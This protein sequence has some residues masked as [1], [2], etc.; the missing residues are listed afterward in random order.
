MEALQD[1]PVIEALHRGSRSFVYRSED[2]VGGGVVIKALLPHADYARTAA[3]LRHAYEV[4]RPFVGRA[5]QFAAFI[6][7]EGL[8]ALVMPDTGGRS[9]DR[10]LVGG[11]LSV[12]QAL[13][14]GVAAA[15]RLAEAH[16]A[17]VV[18]RQVRPEHLVVSADCAAVELIDFSLSARGHSQ[19]SELR[20]VAR[21]ARVLRYAA[22]EQSGRT[23]HLV[24]QRADL[25]SL[26]VVLYE[27]LTGRAPFEDRDALA[28]VHAHLASLPRALTAGRDVPK[29]VDA[30]VLKL[31][32]KDPSA[33]YQTARGLEADLR[34]CREDLLAGRE[35]AWSIGDH[36]APL[37]L[38]PSRRLY[39]R[40]V[41]SAALVDA[42]ERAARGETVYAL[43]R[44]APGVGKSVLVG[45]LHEAAL[46][47]RGAMVSGKFD[48]L[49][50]VPLAG[51]REAL[52]QLALD[53]AA[54][55]PE[56]SASLRR[57]LHASLDGLAPVV[58]DLAPEF[59]LILG[60]QAA[61]TP[62]GPV[63]TQHRLN[64]A[65][66]SLLRAVA[67]PS[68]PLC[69][70]I[71]D[72]QWAGPTTLG[73]LAAVIR[74]LSVEGLLLVGALRDSDPGAGAAL[75]L[76][77]S[78]R[79]DGVEVIDV[80][81]R[82]LAVDAAR[83]LLADTLQRDP[84]DVSEL[85]DALLPRTGGNP[86]FTR[87]LLVTLHRRGAF[88]YDPRLRAWTWSL[89]GVR[90]LS[91]A[92]DVVDLMVERLRSLPDEARK[93]M[94][95]AACIGNRARLGVV[96]RLLSSGALDTLALLQPAIAA[97]LIVPDD[98]PST[99]EDPGRL[100]LSFPHD[101]VQ[102]AAYRLVPE[103]Q[104]AQT[105]L[106]IGRMLSEG[107]DP[108]SLFD[109]AHHLNEG[110]AE[111]TDPLARLELARLDLRAGERAR[112]AGAFDEAWSFLSAGIEMLPDGAWASHYD[113]SLSLTLLAAEAAYVVGRFDDMRDLLSGAWPRLR[114]DVDR[115][116]SLFLEVRAHNSR[117]ELDRSLVKALE[118][119]A[120]LGV[121]VPLK[122]RPDHV[123]RGLARAR[124][125]LARH[126]PERLGDRP[127]ETDP[128]VLLV[129]RVLSEVTSAAYLASPQLW[130]LIVLTLTELSTRS[131]VA[132]FTPLALSMYGL[133]LTALEDFQGARR[134]GDIAEALSRRPECVEFGPRTAFVNCDFIRHWVMPHR[135]VIE[136]VREAYREAVTLGDAEWAGYCAVVWIF[137]SVISGAPLREVEAEAA[138]Y[139]DALRHQRVTLLMHDQWRQV[140]HGLMGRSQLGP[141]CLVGETAFDERVA[142]AV[143]E[144]S[145]DFTSLAT[146][147][148]NKVM[149]AVVLGR[150]AEAAPH[151]ERA[152]ALLH[153]LVGA[154]MYAYF[155]F[156]KALARL[157]ALPAGA[158]ARARAIADAGVS[159]LRLER[160]SVHG[161]MNYRHRASLVRAEIA[162]VTGA[163][164]ASRA[165]ESAIEGARA[166]GF[167]QDEALACELAGRWRA[168]VGDAR[169]ARAYLRD[170]WRLYGEW[171]A[172]AKVELLEA[173]HPWL[174]VHRDEAVDLDV[175]A[176]ARAGQA[177]SREVEL[178]ALI[179]TLMNT[180]MQVAGAT[181]G[182]LFMVDGATLT[183]AARVSDAG[184]VSLVADAAGSATAPAA[185]SVVRWVERTGEAVRL[186]D[187]T[188]GHRFRADPRLASSEARS[189]LCVPIARESRTVGVIYLE[190]DLTNDAFSADRARV[191]ELLCGQIA[192]SL[193]NA[194]L[195][196]S[197]SEALTAQVELSRAQERF[198][199]EPFL[200]SLGRESIV[201]VELGQH[202]EKEL[203][204]LFSDIR[205]FTRI[206]AELGPEGSIAFINEYLGHLEPSIVAHGGF[207]DSY[208][209]DAIMALFEG[210]ADDAVAAA[211]G[212]RAGL[213]RYNRARRARGQGPVRT[214]VGVSVGPLMLGTI[215]GSKHIK[216]GVIG[217]DV[218]L[219]ARVESLTRFY[220]VDLL[221]ADRVV[222]RLG[223][224]DRWCLRRV[225]R[226]QVVG[227]SAPT[228]VW[229]VVD[230]GEADDVDA[231]V[232][233][234]AALHAAQEA[235]WAGSFA[236]ALGAFEACRDA[237]PDDRVPV[238]FAERCRRHLREGVD[239][240]WDG[241]ERFTHK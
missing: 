10:V 97:G 9:L 43:V 153:H 178:D 94:A 118:A 51:V 112:G 223:R 188:S 185:M 241:V 205:G 29:R 168:S 58:V 89:E 161:G 44:G 155:H 66:A 196:A 215:G 204:V 91:V 140:V 119:A 17:G 88:T 202:T 219:A 165:Y 154:P 71:D 171:G 2:R 42:L 191:V 144:R 5:E 194:R 76:A 60:P 207:V 230:G 147:H 187:A 62:L 18:H 83:A 77:R 37:S 162:R 225:D 164:G 3:S 159:L 211:V 149:L 234:R 102:E 53:L 68:R 167:T 206:V 56:E 61:P 78:L 86:Y 116:R 208:I 177:I 96:A 70:F 148:I 199:P 59:A 146:F 192:I 238:I 236:E 67:S 120:L 11:P 73:L 14:L 224:P 6:E 228:T 92:D 152:S 36:D 93:A 85:V 104:R 138:R 128:R 133:S 158:G 160:W 190:N 175:A 32:A 235:Y 173:E 132:P 103:G 21:S 16:A 84:D 126:P 212:M 12:E 26:G 48:Q 195:Y 189:V 222:E 232:A 107:G 179:R 98:D 40:E 72:L 134:F 64:L 233:T 174:R 129:G 31:L 137:S 90:S 55:D 141:F 226:V 240:G 123:L 23:G 127:A 151:V 156:Y 122:P 181:A 124:L 182:A 35:P 27:A 82:P 210:G 24:D 75:E 121:V 125:S 145:G 39:G 131:G 30:V 50:N 54:R 163:P 87:E 47:R 15:R 231:R 110:R 38:S 172:S 19:V 209:G 65:V 198:V 46:A 74:D 45:A 105:H 193:E 197:V 49:S 117:H 221:V 157:R 13:S 7:R 115:A 216:C 34:R 201:G 176:I 20:G 41:E 28:L 239:A 99:L 113:L 217:D 136:P 227:R 81:L 237:T 166:H 33:R 213:R 142:P 106:H 186:G 4:T 150:E 130:L 100:G 95:L 139:S 143:L 220:G 184:R 169:V 180:V 214:G 63:E 200:R 135:G 170:A 52:R 25:Y 80:P 108:E 218:N 101:R 111:L 22:P 183:C 203:A 79:G 8:A 57:S 1:Y 69:L 229:E 114:T 109:V